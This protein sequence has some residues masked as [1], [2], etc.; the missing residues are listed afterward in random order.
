MFNL[1]L[2][3]KEQSNKIDAK[4]ERNKKILANSAIAFGVVMV[5]SLLTALTISP[6]VIQI[7]L[8]ILLL[9]VGAAVAIWSQACFYYIIYAAFRES[10][11]E[12]FMLIILTPIT[13]CIFYI[14]YA[15]VKST[16]LI[17]T[18]AVFGGFFAIACFAASVY[19]F[20]GGTMTLT[21][22]GNPIAI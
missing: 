12:G 15:Y 11:S 21:P 9:I 6:I 1:D 18:I 7:V 13:L 3:N 4:K 10:I 22:F 8:G 20:S 5:V 2:F 14:Y 16:F 17:A 19:A